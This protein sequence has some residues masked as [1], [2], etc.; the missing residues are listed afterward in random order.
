MPR[1]HLRDGYVLA[2]VLLFVQIAA[3]QVP[4]RPT[5]Q[6]AQPPPAQPAP[7]AADPKAERPTDEPERPL[8]ADVETTV[9]GCLQRTDAQTLPAG[10]LLKNASSGDGNPGAPSSRGASGE[11]SATQRPAETASRGE[12]SDEAKQSPAREYRLAIGT[13]KTPLESFVG[14]QVEVKGRVTPEPEP[15]PPTSSEGVSSSRPSGSTGTPT[16]P[17]PT[18]APSGAGAKRSSLPTLYVASIRSLSASCTPPA[19]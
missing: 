6:P 2:A 15:P 8:A 1:Q 4:P 13:A 17:E 14:Q 7:P 18:S 16:V 3:A 12:A 9:T 11:P 5:P 19:R 10:F